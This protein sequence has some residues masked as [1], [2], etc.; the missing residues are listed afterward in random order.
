MAFWSN[1][2]WKFPSKVPTIQKSMVDATMAVKDSEAAV[3]RLGRIIQRI[4]L[5]NQ[6][7][8]FTEPFGL[9]WSDKSLFPRAL[10][11]VLVNFRE[12][13]RRADLF[14]SLPN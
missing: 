3:R 5:A 6:Q 11:H 1:L 14:S 7:P 13:F 4:F 9:E 12:T 2:K 8:A 10:S